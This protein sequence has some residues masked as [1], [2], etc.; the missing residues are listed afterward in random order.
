[1]A[2]VALIV[3]PAQLAI[4]GIVRVS[5][6]GPIQPYPCAIGTCAQ[7]G[8]IYTTGSVVGPVIAI[9]GLSFIA[10]ILAMGTVS[11]MLVEAYTGHTTSFTESL[12]FVGKHL[13]SL[14]AVA[15]LTGLAIVLS[16]FALFLPAIFLTVCWC[17]V[18]PVVVFENKGVFGSIGRSLSLVL[19][20]W[21][22]VFAALILPLLIAIGIIVGVPAALGG[23]AS[24]SSNITAILL[25]S[26]AGRA[27]G[28]ILAYPLIAAI[29]TVIYVKLRVRKENLDPAQLTQAWAPEPTQPAT[30]GPIA[31]S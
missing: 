9:V 4:F 14:V 12:A 13:L 18:V 1:M 24:S 17:V 15:I 30:A 27:I 22:Q 8:T 10:A 7:N 26:A 11:R 2:A 28:T 29:T 31:R 25:L 6:A 16:I 5:L 21:F 20:Q 3:I 19:D 23:L